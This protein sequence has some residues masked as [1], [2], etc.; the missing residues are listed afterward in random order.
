LKAA[1]IRHS[2]EPFSAGFSVQGRLAQH[3]LGSIR[4]PLKERLRDLAMFNLAIDSKLRGCDLVALRV[5]DVQLSGRRRPEPGKSRTRSG[6][7]PDLYTSTP[8]RD[9]LRHM[10]QAHRLAGELS[11]QGARLAVAT[12]EPSEI[13]KVEFKSKNH[14]VAV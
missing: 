11:D 4:V 12:G 6:S 9:D 14:R 1:E 2:G 5:D 8:V 13:E 10:A 3:C 7:G